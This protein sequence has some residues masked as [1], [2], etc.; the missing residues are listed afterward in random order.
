MPEVR[1]PDRRR[2]RRVRM[3]QGLR[4]RP[5]NPKDAQFEEISTTKDVSQDGAY[6]V[7]ELDSYYEGMRLFVTLPYY[8]A[9]SPQ[10]YHYLAQVARIDDLENSQKGIAVRLLSAATKNSR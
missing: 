7:T 5:S 4:V 2:N 3:K 6:F 9:N 1:Q 8:A 10:N